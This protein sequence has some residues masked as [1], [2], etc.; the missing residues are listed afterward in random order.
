[1]IA[2]TTNGEGNA[3]AGYMGAQAGL[4]YYTGAGNPPGN[5]CAYTN[6][7]YNLSATSSWQNDTTGDGAC[8]G[9]GYYFGKGNSAAYDGS[10]YLQVSTQDSRN[11]YG[12]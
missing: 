6:W 12:A 9:A 2:H 4:Y 11:L 7:A 8:Y 3:P 10:G 5:L 1:M